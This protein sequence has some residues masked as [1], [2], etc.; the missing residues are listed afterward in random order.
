MGQQLR[1]AAFDVH[2]HTMARWAALIQAIEAG[3]MPDPRRGTLALD[4]PVSVAVGGVR[5]GFPLGV[6]G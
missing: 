5:L 2:M 4:R 1:S 6:E 3:P